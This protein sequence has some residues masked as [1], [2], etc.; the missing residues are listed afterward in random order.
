MGKVV[1]KKLVRGSIHGY[2]RVLVSR[3]LRVIRVLLFVVKAIRLKLSEMSNQ[4]TLMRKYSARLPKVPQLNKRTVPLFLSVFFAMILILQSSIQAA[5]DLSDD[6]DFS[7]P[8]DYTYDSGIEVNGGVAR[9][10]ALNY[11]D[12]ADTSALYHFDE[13]GGTNISDSS[14]NNNAGTMVGGSFVT[15]NLNNAIQLNGDSDG[16]SAPSIS[17]TQLGQQ[18]SIEGWTKFSNAFNASSHDRRNAV[19]DKGSYQL[20]YDNETGKLTYEILDSSTQE[21]DQ[22]SGDDRLGSWDRDGNL[23]VESST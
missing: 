16:V 4:F 12:D 14:S 9:L 19:V 21:W 13:S 17:A 1:L 15:G 3:F 20:Y 18:H 23:T 11:S 2:I 6:W 8:A 10:K 22:V 5:P 7:V